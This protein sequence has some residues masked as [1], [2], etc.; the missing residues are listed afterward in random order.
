[1]LPHLLPVAIF[2]EGRCVP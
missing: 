2:F 1:M